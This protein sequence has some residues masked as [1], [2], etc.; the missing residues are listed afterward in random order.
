MN[1]SSAQPEDQL[2]SA[3]EY[4]SLA[5]IEKCVVIDELQASNQELGAILDWLLSARDDLRDVTVCDDFSLISNSNEAR[6]IPDNLDLAQLKRE[7]D[8]ILKRGQFVVQESMLLRMRSEK[9]R[10]AL[11]LPVDGHSKSLRRQARTSGDDADG[12]WPRAASRSLWNWELPSRP[13]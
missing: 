2:S 4:L 1:A 13:W 10:A 5:L 8:S 3:L 7:A 6:G 11:V 9:V 12:G